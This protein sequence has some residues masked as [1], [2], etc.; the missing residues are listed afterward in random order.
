MT[1]DNNAPKAPAEMN[2]KVIDIMAYL[3]KLWVSR[4]LIYKVTGIAM[5]LGILIA[6]T[7]PKTYSV[8]VILAPESTKSSSGSLA[9]AASMLGLG[10]LSL[11][12]D[13]DA[14]KITLY[15]DIVNSTP[16]IVDL[17]NTQVHTKKS[18]EMT[19]LEEYVKTNRKSL[20]KRVISFPF[21]LLGKVVSLFKDDN[22]NGQVAAEVNPAQLTKA[23]YRVANTLRRQV[24]ASVDKK[25]GVT[26]ISVTMQDPMVAAMVADTVVTKLKQYITK[27]RTSKAEE[28]YKYWEEIYEKR[29]AE[30]YEAQKRYADYADANRNVVLQSVLNE[31]ER[32]HNEKALALQLYT[33]VAT[34]MQMARAKVQE[35][36]PVFAIVEPATVPLKASS[37]SRSMTVLQFMAVGAVLAALWILFGRDMVSKIR[38]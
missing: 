24:G 26:T 11:G 16:F 29:R 27:Y 19:S 12:S 10:N 14:L 4:R 15:P 33:T 30:Y 23:Q 17:F 6:F 20:V 7:T 32:L 1:V 22:Q 5:A 34:Q 8:K 25:T 28:D 36:K 13:N 2:D 38:K 37:T 18:E 31:R 35:A 3:S 21:T 9:S